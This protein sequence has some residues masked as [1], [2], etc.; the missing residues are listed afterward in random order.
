MESPPEEAPGLIQSFY[1]R[2]TEYSDD[3]LRLSKHLMD[4]GHPSP[5]SPLSRV[6]ARGADA[7]NL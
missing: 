6:G 2:I 7:R 3:T 1:L 4:L 5:P